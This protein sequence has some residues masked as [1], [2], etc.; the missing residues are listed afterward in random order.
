MKE[1]HD[2]ITLLTPFQFKRVGTILIAWEKLDDIVVDA[3]KK[4][5]SICSRRWYAVDHIMTDLSF[6]TM[7]LTEKACP[8]GI[9]LEQVEK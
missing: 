9:M 1:R 5:Q 6:P 3:I 4:A 7:V 8:P 2:N